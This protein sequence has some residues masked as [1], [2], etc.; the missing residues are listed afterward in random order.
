MHAH[1]G[2]K[3][4]AFYFNSAVFFQNQLIYK[5]SFITLGPGLTLLLSTEISASKLFQNF[6]TF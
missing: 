1:A 5:K 2:K 6:L 4:Y 3:L